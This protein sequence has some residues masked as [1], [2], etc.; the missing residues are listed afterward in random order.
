MIHTRRTTRG[1]TIIETLVAITILMIAIAGPLTVANKGYTAALDARNQ[2]IAI[3]LAQEGLEYLNNLKDNGAW[4]PKP[5]NPLSGG[6]CVTVSKIPQC[7]ISFLPASN[8]SS[9][10]GVDLC[11]NLNNCALTLKNGDYTYAPTW[12]GALPTPF[13]RY[14]VLYHS[15]DPDGSDD[16]TAYVVVSWTTTYGGTNEVDLSEI[17]TN[18]PR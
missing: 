7:G 18:T 10:P 3:S 2:T 17:L 4:P 9:H 14:F 8:S 11:S 16:Y 5:T 6:S 15:S 13:S 1:F 12:T